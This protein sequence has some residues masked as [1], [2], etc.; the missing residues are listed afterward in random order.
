MS[1]EDTSLQS[2]TGVGH[3][4]EPQQWPGVRL[5]AHGWSHL[6]PPFPSSLQSPAQPRN[7]R[8]LIPPVGLPSTGVGSWPSLPPYG[9]RHLVSPNFS[10]TACKMG[11]TVLFHPWKKNVKHR[12]HNARVDCGTRGSLGATEVDDGQSEHVQSTQTG[13]TYPSAYVSVCWPMKRSHY[14]HLQGVFRG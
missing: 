13:A 14:T 12:Q 3:Q 5:Q 8:A 7:H 2:N 6:L 9:L 11:V 4:H 10:C 1:R